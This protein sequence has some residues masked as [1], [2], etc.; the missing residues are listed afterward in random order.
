MK[1]P[2]KIA[3]VYDWIDSW[4]GVERLLL[5]FHELFPDAIFFTSYTNFKKASW[6]K[7]LTIANSFMQKLPHFIKDNRSLSV[8][9]YPFAFES[10]DFSAFDLV[11]SITS[12][13]AKSIITRPDT[14]HIC[15]LLTPTRFLW[16]HPQAPMLTS[17]LIKHLK[18]WDLIAAQRPDQYIAISKTVHKR[19]KSIYNRDSEVIY[20]P[21]DIEYWDKIKDKANT[22]HKILNNKYF[23]VVSRL[24]QYKRVDLAIKTF[25]KLKD[26][27]LIVVGTGTQESKLKSMSGSNITFL[28]SVLDSDLASIYSNAEA[29]IMPQ[30]EDF[31]YVSLEAQLFGCPVIAFKNGGATETIIEGKTGILFDTQSVE[32]ILNA[33]A[34]FDKMSYTLKEST[35]KVGLENVERFSKR[36][37]TNQFQ[38]FV[39][40]KI[41]S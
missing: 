28:K 36:K 20:P 29:L 9:F 35:R 14:L 38:A 37:F 34:N 26:K 13:F 4:G 39:N 24:E 23:L 2:Q 27:K 22:K 18:K 11:I 15:Y 21:F 12:S 25:N 41:K 5:Q 8:P 10:F 19:L 16:T 17:P 3:I 1:T 33:L 30:E 40:S 7:D 31:G 6:A 32:A